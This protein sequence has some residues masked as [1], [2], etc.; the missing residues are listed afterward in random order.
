MTFDRLNKLI[1]TGSMTAAAALLLSTAAFAQEVTED[2]TTVEIAIDPAVDYGPVQNWHDLN[3]GDE[4]QGIA[5]GEP[6]PTTG[7]ARK[8]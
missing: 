5:V 2:E 4:V 6:D 7:G 8:W 3:P 1:L